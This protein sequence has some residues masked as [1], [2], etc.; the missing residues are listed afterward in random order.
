M[1]NTAVTLDDKY[2]LDAGR[3]YLT[4]TQALLRVLMV[5]RRRDLAAGLNTAGFV[6]GYRG[7]PM[8]AIDVELWRAKQHTKANH[9]EFWPAINEHMAATAVWGTQ[10][11]GHFNDANYDGVYS[12]WYGKGPGLDQAMD[13]IRQGNYF[14]SSKHGGVL[15]LSGD[16]PAMRSTVVAAS[17]E[18][19]FENLLM[20]VLYP[21][22][23]QD[24]FDLALYGLELSRFS[25]AWVG[26]KLLPETIETAAS[27]RGDHDHIQFVY[28][29]FEFPPD[30]VNSRAGDLYHGQEHRL[31]SFKLPAAIAFARA[32]KLNRVTHDSPR[33][34]FGIAAM[35]KTWR[36]TL[37]ALEDL[38]I[39]E[40]VMSAIGIRILKVAMPFP[41]DR[42]TY[43]EFADGLED[44]LVIEDKFEQIEN[45]LRNVCYGLPAGRQPRIVGRLDE[46]GQKLV[47][48]VGDL[49]ADKIS[50]L[51]ASRISSFHDNERT[52]A[53]IAFL[54]R[55][56]QETQQREALSLARLPYFCSGCP[57]NTSTRVP[58]GSR[59]GGGVGCHFMANW[60]DREVH[61]YT[62]MGGEGAPWI[63]QAPFVGTPHIFQTASAT[64]PTTTRAQLAVR[65]AAAAGVNVTY[66]ILYNDAV[67]MTGGQHCRRP[68]HR[69]A[70]HAD[71]ST[72]RGQR[73]ESR[74]SPTSRTSIRP[75]PN[76]GFARR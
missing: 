52:R 54:D 10:Q 14:G 76:P 51:I 74:W 72:Q 28:P 48:D 45:A 41:V 31:R 49:S 47:D 11:V 58:E 26:Y 9:I 4:G 23:I 55:Q 37:Q 29:N 16:D 12:M 68:A 57:H 43:A 22:D 46:N 5:Q 70:D 53:R 33:A 30:G 2:T 36:D 75:A 17:S 35:G 59:A 67:A 34:R 44:I 1:T 18:L 66:K 15:F 27:I 24:V 21:A 42:E 39:D 73:S 38:G 62:Q 19:I 20:P 32:N 65:A 25:G 63:G 13:A 8:T 3:V 7:S 61:G 6:S 60:M 40:S 69:A 64:A 71:R 50:R 56:L